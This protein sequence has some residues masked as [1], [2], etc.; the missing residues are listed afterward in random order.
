MLNKLTFDSTRKVS[1]GLVRTFHKQYALLRFGHP[2]RIKAYHLAN[3]IR[4]RL[5]PD[6]GGNTEVFQFIIDEVDGVLLLYVVEFHERLRHRHIIILSGDVLS[7]AMPA[8]LQP[9]CT[10]E[11]GDEAERHQ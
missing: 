9:L 6:A 3:D 2:Y 5:V 7:R 11:Y 4:H 8:Y 1:V 10:D